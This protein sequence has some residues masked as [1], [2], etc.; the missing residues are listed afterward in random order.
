[1]SLVYLADSKRLIDNASLLLHKI[2]DQQD[3]ESKMKKVD[4]WNLFLDLSTTT[5]LCYSLVVC[6]IFQFRDTSCN[7]K[8]L[9]LTF[10]LY[11][12]CLLPCSETLP[13]SRFESALSSDQIDPLFRHYL[14]SDYR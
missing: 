10:E 1:M 5:Y 7:H 9:V 3:C 6:S 4:F 13:Y 12:E 11:F 14:D 8:R 2:Y